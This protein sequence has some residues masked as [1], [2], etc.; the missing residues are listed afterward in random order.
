M[1]LIY[2]IR[3]EIRREG[4]LKEAPYQELETIFTQS[5]SKN[6]L[7]FFIPICTDLH[8]SAQVFYVYSYTSVFYTW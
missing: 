4:R 3:V 8:Y 1:L 2:S 6:S 7:S 5:Y